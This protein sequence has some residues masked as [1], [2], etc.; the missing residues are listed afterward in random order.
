Y[1]DRQNDQKQCSTSSV[2]VIGAGQS[3]ALG[4]L[5]MQSETRRAKDKNASILGGVPM[6]G[7]PESKD[8]AAGVWLTAGTAMGTGNAP[9][10]TFTKDIPRENK[11]PMAFVYGGGDKKAAEFAKS[12]SV[13]SGKDKE[14]GY[15][16][17]VPVSNVSTAGHRLL[18]KGEESEKVILDTLRTI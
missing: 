15:P 16:R 13:K 5:W 8:L 9:W 10:N 6:L 14:A 2:I 17:A 1:L 7:E 12:Y 18:G 11:V 4:A 3:A